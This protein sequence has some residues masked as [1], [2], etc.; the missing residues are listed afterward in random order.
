MPWIVIVFGVFVGPLGAVSVILVIIQPVLF[1]TF[2][3][4][5]LAS[6]AISLA[7]IGPAAD[8]ILAALQHL[9][10]VRAGG[11]SVWRACWGMGALE[12]PPADVGPDGPA[13]A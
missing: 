6:A 10:R 12:Q 13:D 1:D 9:R 8:E 3:T 5:C 7:M 11:R 4:L 2:C